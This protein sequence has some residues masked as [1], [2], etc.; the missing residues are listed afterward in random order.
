M[1]VARRAVRAA[2]APIRGFVRRH[3]AS[4]GSLVAV[5]TQEPM[6]A[7]TFD[8]GPAVGGTDV[9]LPVLA[10]YR[11]RATFFVLLTAARRHPSLL[12]EVV[13]AGHEIGLHGID[14]RALTTLRNSDVR[15][16]QRDGR[17]ELEDLAGAQVRWMRPPYGRQSLRTWRATR[18]AGMTTAMWGASTWDWRDI[19]Q[20]QR[21]AHCLPE[22]HRGVILLA[23]DGF[24]GPPDGVAAGPP[25]EVD[26]A[27]LIDRV[28]AGAGEKGLSA[29]SLGNLVGG[30]EAVLAASFR[31]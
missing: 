16:R 23:H 15:R 31:R 17:A 25:P 19:D 6:F 12:A 2:A 27:D 29:V 1:S 24:A 10:E 8:D 4:I 20:H 28:L 26:R 30:G 22:L 7:L 18:A 11:A 21:L 3:S 13:A 9:L 14:H 5:D